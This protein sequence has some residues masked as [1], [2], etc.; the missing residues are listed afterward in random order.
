MLMEGGGGI[1]VTKQGRGFNIKINYYLSIRSMFVW[2][3]FY[4]VYQRK[5]VRSADAVHKTNHSA[6]IFSMVLYWAS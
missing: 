2:S 4:Y 1:F 6:T 3:Y 5:H